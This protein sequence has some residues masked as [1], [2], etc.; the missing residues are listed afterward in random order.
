M[1]NNYFGRKTKVEIGK[2]YVGNFV[3]MKVQ[4]LK[5]N[6]NNVQFKVIEDNEYGDLV[7]ESD[8][9]QMDDFKKHWNSI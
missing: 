8:Q 2:N 7:G 3:D 6:N 9:L 1:A 5:I 4:I